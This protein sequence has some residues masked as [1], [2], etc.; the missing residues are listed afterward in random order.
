[1]ITSRRHVCLPHVDS[2]MAHLP[3]ILAPL[4]CQGKKHVC[5]PPQTCLRCPS[6][7]H[8][9]P[10]DGS[11]QPCSRSWWQGP[12]KSNSCVRCARWSLGCA[13]WWCD[14]KK[15]ALGRF[16]K[17]VDRSG[18]KEGT[19]KALVPRDNIYNK[20]WT[21]HMT[22]SSRIIYLRHLFFW[23]LQNK[24]F[25]GDHAYGMPIFYYK[26][27]VLQKKWTWIVIFFTFVGHWVTGSHMA[28][29]YGL[30]ICS[31]SHWAAW[32]MTG[33]HWGQAHNGHAVWLLV[34]QFQMKVKK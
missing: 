8:I 4:H 19:P 25:C 27:R 9:C 32:P 12:F 33:R 7:W 30:A 34:T 5:F 3:P 23:W 26:P 15:V 16:G 11:S 31:L 24:S 1:M 2:W 6:C 10:Q 28:W 29:P 17:K 14:S 21:C 18:M 13:T 22:S 20:H